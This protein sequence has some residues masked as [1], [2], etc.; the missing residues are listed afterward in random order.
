MRWTPRGS[1]YY[2]L[3]RKRDEEMAERARI[4]HENKGRQMSE[5]EKHD[6]V[7]AMAGFVG[8]LMKVLQAARVVA[9]GAPTEHEDWDNVVALQKAIADFD[10][11]LDAV[12]GTKTM[13]DCRQDGVCAF[14]PGCRRHWAERT[15]ELAADYA[16][17]RK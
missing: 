2:L 9:A 5:Q 12:T 6:G 7:V 10:A 16:A 11:P 15:I 8:A 3:A 4:A 14:A 1:V 17:G 13:G